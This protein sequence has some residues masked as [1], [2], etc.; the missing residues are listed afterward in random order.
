[1]LIAGTAAAILLTLGSARAAGTP[2]TAQLAPVQRWI[3]AFNASQSPLPEDVFTSDVVITDQFAPYAWNGTA[4]MHAWST[5]IAEGFADPRV[6]HERVVT[7]APISYLKNKTGDRVSFVLPATLTYE[8]KGKPQTDKAL[9]LFVVVKDGSDW[10]I[11]A[12]TWT[13]TE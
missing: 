5:S 10:K 1:M 6:A 3:D 2:D 7:G 13:K 9:W 4:A 12:D 8:F 11:A